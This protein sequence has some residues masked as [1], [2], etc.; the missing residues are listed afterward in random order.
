MLDFLSLKTEAFG[1]DISDFSLK[2][3]KLKKKRDYLALASFGEETI[4]PGIILEGEIKDEESLAKII[5]KGFLEAKGEKLKTKY[6]ITSLPEEKTFLQVIQVPKMTE[7]ELKKAV[8]FEAENYIP[9]PAAEA[10]LDFQVVQPFSDH[11]DHIDILLVALPK[12]IVDPYVSSIKKAGLIPVALEIESQA[13]ARAVIKKGVSSF[14]LLLIDLGATRTSFII[15]SG[16]SLRF[17]SS[18]PVSSQKFTEAIA[19][20][21]QVSLEEAEKLKVEYGLERDKKKGE[22]VF[23]ALIPALTDLIEQLKIHL[24]YYQT[25]SFHEH[26][27][28]DGH[29]VEKIFLFGGG[30]NLKGLKDFIGREL[31]IPVEIGNPWVNILAEKPQ[32]V[33]RLPYERSLGYTTA[34]GLA[35]RGVTRN[36]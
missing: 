21:L 10:Y 3:I 23:E 6:V 35:L 4:P 1:L 34:L 18:I 32:E 30:A 13:I 36:D 15:F 11:L 31:M 25:H 9:L 16:Y 8:R 27:P 12:K 29:G 14:P 5:K 33:P 28:P 17:T 22:I 26:L 20:N 24:R 19:K 2:I 7:E